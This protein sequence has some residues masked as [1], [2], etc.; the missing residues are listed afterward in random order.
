MCLQIQ[1]GQGGQ[2]RSSSPRDKKPAMPAHVSL[3]LGAASAF[4]GGVVG[5]PLTVVRTRLMVQGM[6][7]APGAHQ[8]QHARAIGNASP[9]R[10]EL[11]FGTPL[12]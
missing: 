5:Y 2:R 6:G 10:A 11:P 9:F 4:C 3:G 12:T 1:A 8:Y 7:G